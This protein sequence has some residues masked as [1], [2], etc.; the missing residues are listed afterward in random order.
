MSKHV[1]TLKEI[2]ERLDQITNQ[3]E[4]YIRNEKGNLIEANT[5]IVKAVGTA[6]FITDEQNVD[7]R[8]RHTKLTP[9]VRKEIYKLPDIQDGL[10]A[11]QASFWTDANPLNPTPSPDTN[12]LIFLA[13]EK[14]RLATF[15]IYHHGDIELGDAEASSNVFGGFRHW[16]MLKP[17][18]EKFRTKNGNYSGEKFK[19]FLVGGKHEGR[20]YEPLIKEGVWHYDHTLT[21][22]S[23]FDRNEIERLNSGLKSLYAEIEPRYNFY[24]KNY[25]MVMSSS[26]SDE[27]SFPNMYVFFAQKAAQEKFKEDKAKAKQTPVAPNPFYEEHITL[28]DSIKESTAKA[29]SMPFDERKDFRLDDPAGQ[30]YDMWSVAYPRAKKKGLLD[31]TSKKF[32]NVYFPL[33]DMGLLTG[34]NRQQYL[35]PMYTSIEFST[36]ATTQFAEVLKQTQLSSVFTMDLFSSGKMKQKKMFQSV[37][38]SVQAKS[39]SDSGAGASLN[40]TKTHYTSSQR[41]IFD[42]E[43]WMDNFS[44]DSGTSDDGLDT[45]DGI[46]IGAYANEKKVSLDPQY[47]FWKSLMAVILKGKVKKIVDNH[48]RTYKEIMSGKQSYHETVCYRVA[49]HKGNPSGEPMQ[50]FYFPN[51]N[52]IDVLKF[53]D[54]QVKYGE[55][56]TYVVYAYELVVGSKYRYEKV[57]T[58]PAGALIQVTIAPSLKIIET[59][60]YSKN[61]IMID[62]PPVHPE[63]EM[64]PYRAVNDRVRIQLNGSVGKYN[65]HPQHIDEED[66]NQTRKHLRAQSKLRGEKIEY[67]GDDH[68]KAFQIWRLDRKPGRYSDF[69][70]HLLKTVRTGN[71]YFQASSATFIDKIEPN[72]KYYYTFRSVD[73]H[74][75]ISHPTPIYEYEMIDDSGSVYPIMQ[76]VPIDL[77]GSR[78]KSKAGKRFIRIYPSFGNTMPELS[79]VNVASTAREVR[80]VPLGVQ[81]EKTWG[82]KFKIRIKSTSTGKQVDFNVTFKHKHVKD[83]KTVKGGR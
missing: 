72:K 34:A 59:P 11:A 56:Y 32:R 17:K 71:G 40:I 50:N 68:P 36:D 61:V 44:S 55:R 48:S 27:L 65:M 41:R 1:L 12:N 39:D 2:E 52:E 80:A 78:Q 79:E 22:N 14:P 21:L 10:R 64:V 62:S 13:N 47:K 66:H 38:T 26:Q 69:N 33:G 4:K 76:V 24:I 43:T 77:T 46:F 18:K 42:L 58:S 25:E 29:M 74:G 70:G 30:Y 67:Q 82:K 28:G 49:K 45:D 15:N 75:N 9:E 54:T 20:S 35:F 63:V 5:S 37:K 83:I 73:V 19:K 53:V 3:P 23:P 6:A 81:D 8:Y 16:F 7:V 57:V 60:Y 31:K 51:S